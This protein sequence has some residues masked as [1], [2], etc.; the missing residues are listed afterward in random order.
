MNLDEFLLIHPFFCLLLGYESHIHYLKMHFLILGATGRNGILV[1]KE[2]LDRNHSV[3]ALVRNPDKVL[4]H[5]NLTLLKGSPLSEQDISTAL[6]MPEF[7]SSILITLAQTRKTDSP[8]SPLNPDVPTDFI[9][10]VIK[11]ILSA[12]SSLG[13]RPKIV[14]N[15]S[16]GAGTSLYSLPWVLRF[17][18]DHSTMKWSRKDHDTVD[19][20]VRNSGLP[21]VLARP[22]RLV[23]AVQGKSSN[24]KVLDDS[25]NGA[26][27]LAQCEREAVA[28]FLV[29]AAEKNDWDNLS[30]VLVTE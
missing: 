27:F 17:L 26:N 3:T 7:P 24:L 13:A 18:F 8:F 29:D 5:R 9:S 15:S 20:I 12:V 2:A 21:F 25:G 14:V 6:Q 10:Q 1:M 19:E 16:Q 23:E 22:A 28:T 11:L 4:P 30:P